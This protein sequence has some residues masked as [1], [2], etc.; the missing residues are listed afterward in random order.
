[1]LKIHTLYYKNIF[2][3]KYKIKIKNNT[4]NPYNTESINQKTKS[5]R[6]IKNLTTHSYPRKM[7]IKLNTN[8]CKDL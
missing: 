4:I 3:N 2:F 7:F 5:I 8:K 6:K 1:M